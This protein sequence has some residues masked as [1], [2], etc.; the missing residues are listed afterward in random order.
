[1][2]KVTYVLLIMLPMY[3]KYEIIGAEPLL[4]FR[5]CMLKAQEH[6]DNIEGRTFAACM[7]SIRGT[8]ADNVISK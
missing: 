5:Q 7:P 8:D 2:I 6:N 3:G 1:M 4:T